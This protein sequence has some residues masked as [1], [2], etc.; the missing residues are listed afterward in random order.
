MPVEMDDGFDDLLNDLEDS[1]PT[2]PSSNASFRGSGAPAPAVSEDFSIDSL[3][4]EADCYGSA[5]S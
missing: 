1:N 2:F 4:D 5:P 3:L